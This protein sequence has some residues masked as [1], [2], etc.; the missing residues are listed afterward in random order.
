[1]SEQM[2]LKLGGKKVKGYERV[3]GLMFRPKRYAKSLV[4]E[5]KKDVRI[6]LHSMFVF[7]PFKVIWF[8]KN[9]NIVEER[10]I[11]PFRPFIRPK[12]KFRRFIEIPL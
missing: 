6:P 5:F 10:I 2:K 3:L 9:D 8:D 7:F 12:A 11:K 1:M 4:F